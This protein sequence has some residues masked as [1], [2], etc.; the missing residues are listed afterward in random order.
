L[1]YTQPDVNY[2]IVCSGTAGQTS[3]GYASLDTINAGGNGTNGPTTNQ[4]VIRGCSNTG[5]N[6][7]D[8]PWMTIAVFA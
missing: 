8:L 7:Q 2:S 6:P 3:S 1:T 5:S 4:F